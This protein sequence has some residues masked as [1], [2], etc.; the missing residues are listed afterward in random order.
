MAL[1]MLSI[2]GTFIITTLLIKESA[3]DFSLFHKTRANENISNFNQHKNSSK[4]HNIEILKDRGSLSIYHNPRSHAIILL[5]AL[6]SPA[7]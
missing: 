2:N 1:I 6:D 5:S 7:N 3:M 4:R